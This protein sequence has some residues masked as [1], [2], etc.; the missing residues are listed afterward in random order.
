MKKE[1]VL[2]E[3]REGRIINIISTSPD[4]EFKILDHDLDYNDEDFEESPHDNWEIDEIMSKE[5]ITEY[6]NQES[7]YTV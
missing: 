6:I 2:L 3:I 4:I 7:N 5:Q 1:T